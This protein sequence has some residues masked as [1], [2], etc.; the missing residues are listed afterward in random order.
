MKVVQVRVDERAHKLMRLVA[1]ETHDTLSGV[2]QQAI[3]AYARELGISD[4]VI[5]R[6]IADG[7]EE[8]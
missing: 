8:N 6:G 1:V 2:F 5:A 3:V 7:D 4:Q